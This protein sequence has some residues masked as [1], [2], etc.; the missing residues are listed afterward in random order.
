MAR[1]LIFST[2]TEEQWRKAHDQMGSVYLILDAENDR[3]K[4]GHSRDPWRRL[5]TLQTGSSSKL[6]LIGIIAGTA[7]VEKRL[8]FDQHDVKVHLEW[9]SGGRA[10]V[11][12]LNRQT[13]NLP[14]CRSFARFAPAQEIDVWW[15]WDAEHR[16]HFKHVYDHGLN[17]WVGP[18]MYSGKVNAR[19]GWDAMATE[20]AAV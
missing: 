10:A 13:G 5:K 14:M 16:I 3:V 8:H 6:E 1:R 12:W 19:P 18:L 9:F 4:I 2:L 20:L 17:K 11:N 15:K 7:D